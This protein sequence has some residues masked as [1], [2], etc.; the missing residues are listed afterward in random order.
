MSDLAGVLAPVLTPFDVSLVPDVP[1]FV[2]HCRWLLA[3]GCSGL[4]IFGT[5]SEANSLSVEERERMLE[6]IVAAGVPPAQLLPGTGCAALPDTVRLTRRAVAAGC[7]GVLVLPPFY[8]K[9]VAEEALFQSYAA[10]I[11]RVNDPRLR[12]FLYHIPQLSAVPVTLG[13]IERL[14]RAFPHVVVGM[15]DSSGDWSNTR[16]VLEAFPGFRV[17]VGSERFLL[18][19]LRGGGAGSITATANVNARAIDLLFR[20]W[21]GPEAERLQAE[22]D[23]VRDVFEQLPAIPALKATLAHF[24]EDPSWSRTRPPLLPL[25]EAQRAQLLAGLREA[26]FALER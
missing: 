15:K 14:R 22:V 6:E 9:N 23:R 24:R 11:E 10:V 19:N 8:Y 16:A 12:V 25:S 20:S 1:R 3:N 21:R 18:A 5:T 7:A 13:L 2:A 4:A 17:F 26:R